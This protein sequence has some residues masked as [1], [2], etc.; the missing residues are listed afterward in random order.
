MKKDEALN[1]LIIYIQN[2]GIEQRGGITKFL[3]NNFNNI[4]SLTS[5]IT[6]KEIIEHLN[7]SLNLNFDYKYFNLAF[8]KIKKENNRIEINPTLKKELDLKQINQQPT[9]KEEVKPTESKPTFKT[10]PIQTPSKKIDS[11]E[12][13]QR[14]YQK[15]ED[16][17]FKENPD[18]KQLLEKYGMFHNFITKKHI[19]RC[20]VTADEL[21]EH[22]GFET[23]ITSG[24]QLGTNIL[25]Y[26]N[27]KYPKLDKM[28]NGELK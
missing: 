17:Y 21:I 15:E 28:L 20:K 23:G 26:L 5:L 6:F 22:C 18:V 16:L 1:E 14:Q 10:Q 12:E 9:K 4:E 13:K 2:I 27:S 8:N 24:V 3:K 11:F 19:V 25:S 7:K